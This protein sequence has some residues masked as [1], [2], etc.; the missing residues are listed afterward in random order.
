MQPHLDGFCGVDASGRRAAIP[1]DFNLRDLGFPRTEAGTTA[2]GDLRAVGGVGI[3]IHNV[4]GR[5]NSGDLALVQPHRGIAEGPHLVQ[6]VGNHHH[7]AAILAKLGELVQALLL[8]LQVTHRQD[9]IHQQDLWFDVDRNREPQTHIHP[10]RIV[11]HRLVDKVLHPG[12]R[13]DFV[14]FSFDFGSAHPQDSAVKKDVFPSRQLGMKTRTNLQHRR[15]APVR[16]DLAAVRGQNLGDALQQRGLAR[17]VLSQQP[18]GRARGDFQRNIF[19]GVELFELGFAL[20]QQATLDGLVAVA[21][22][23]KVLRNMFDLDG[24]LWLCATQL[25]ISSTIQA[26]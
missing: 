4:H 12:K 21:I 18:E 9:F 5:A 1:Q 24:R 13:H 3:A 17:T 8:E 23:P 26:W 19:Q 25:Q 10:R 7:G 22:D 16:S 15:H 2:L 6:G 14:E 11:L 20:A